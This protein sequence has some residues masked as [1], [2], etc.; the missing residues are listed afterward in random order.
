MQK[1][2]RPCLRRKNIHNPRLSPGKRTQSKACHRNNGHHGSCSFPKNWKYYNADEIN[3]QDTNYLL[4]FQSDAG[5]AT[6]NQ[7]LD[8]PL[9]T[10]SVTAKDISELNTKSADLIFTAIL[11]YNIPKTIDSALFSVL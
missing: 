1:R 7:R 8:I 9:L 4:L 10:F 6:P 5:H 2:R 11:E 3:C